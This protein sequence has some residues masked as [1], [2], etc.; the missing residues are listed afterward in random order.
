MGWG[1]GAGA[2]KGDPRGSGGAPLTKVL[3]CSGNCERILSLGS[4]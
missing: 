3:L 4:L 1:V 2:D